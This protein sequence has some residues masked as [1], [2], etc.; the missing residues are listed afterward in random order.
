MN[1][2][3]KPLE[4]FVVSKAAQGTIK[5]TGGL[6]TGATVNLNDGQL[7]FMAAGLNGSV[8]LNNFLGASP[9]LAASTKSRIVQGTPYSAS[10]NTANVAYPLS[11]RSYEQTEIIDWAQ[12]VTITKQAYRA[13]SHAI[14]VIGNIIGNAAAVNV[15]SNTEYEIALSLRGRR[16]EEDLSVQE[17]AYIR[18]NIISPDFSATGLNYTNTQ[19][20]SYLTTQFV[21]DLNKKS[22]AFGYNSRFAN[23]GPFVA[24]LIKNVGGSGKAIGGV[25]PIA[26][27]DVV[28]VTTINGVAKQITVTDDMATAIKAAAVAA[29]AVAIASVTWTIENANVANG[30]SSATEM[31][32]IVA[33]DART[34]YDDRIPQVK[35]DI[36]V[37][38]P[39][40]FNYQTVG[41]VKYTFANEGQGIARALE[42]QYQSAAQTKYNL[43]HDLIPQTKYDSPI[44]A[45]EKYVTYNIRHDVKVQNGFGSSIG[46]NKLSRVLI[47][48]F[49][50]GV[51]VNPAIALMDTA[52]ASYLTSG[53]Q[54]S[55]VNLD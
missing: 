19:A 33:L 9:T 11:V 35:T 5:T 1:I 50:S 41:N 42:I 53:S 39:L 31:I 21:V 20:T 32:M 52:L 34:G 30:G 25:T 43:E 44:V 13:P 55:I 40:G 28:T 7:A 10:V 27:G 15:L 54:G 26:A 47:P 17:S 14:T 48:A 49:S 3:S 6:I 46:F 4:T 16:I 22:A 8:A 18:S 24:L 37:N 29:Q 23:N 45:N 12:P 2:N 38:L 36:K 51:T